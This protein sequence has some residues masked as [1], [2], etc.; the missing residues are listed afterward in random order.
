MSPLFRTCL[1]AQ[2]VGEQALWRGEGRGGS[3]RHA[4]GFT[5]ADSLHPRVPA[6]P[7]ARRFFV[8]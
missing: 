6:S 2:L 5:H 3:Q 7:Q 4:F 8:L 1:S